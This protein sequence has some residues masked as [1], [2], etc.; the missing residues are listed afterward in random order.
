MLADSGQTSDG[1][2]SYESSRDRGRATGTST[3]ARSCTRLLT[4]FARRAAGG[5]DGRSRSVYRDARERNDPHAS[6]DNR[7]KWRPNREEA[8]RTWNR[9]AIAHSI[10]YRDRRS[11]NY[12]ARSH[13]LAWV[14]FPGR[15][16]R[17]SWPWKLTGS[18]YGTDCRYSWRP[19]IKRRM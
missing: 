17:R 13:G 8:T 15:T 16:I 9:S 3:S 1:R 18:F 10:D 2:C 12:L 19:G 11:I 4:H 6:E 7:S 5:G 14:I